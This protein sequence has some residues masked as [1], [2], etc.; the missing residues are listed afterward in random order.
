MRGLTK[1]YD[2]V[3]R[4][5]G[6]NGHRPAVDRITMAVLPGECFGLLG[7]NGAGKTTTFRI[8]TGDLDPSGGLV[9]INGYDMNLELRQVRLIRDLIF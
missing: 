4:S 7:V 6:H 8:I 5:A 9:L 2:L 1:T 3:G